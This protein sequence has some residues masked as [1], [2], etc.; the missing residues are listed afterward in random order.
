MAEGRPI[1]EYREMAAAA[2]LAMLDFQAPEGETEQQV[3]SVRCSSGMLTPVFS[4][5]VFRSPLVFIDV[6]R[7]LT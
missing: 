1:K 3:S 5:T 6:S 4:R 7:G 2:G